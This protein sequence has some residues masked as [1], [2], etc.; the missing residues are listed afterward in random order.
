MAYRGLFEP[1]CPINFIWHGTCLSTSDLF[2][3]KKET[4]KKRGIT[5]RKVWFES[6]GMVW[7]LG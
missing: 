7:L 4:I 6:C 5:K 2:P 3:E 1:N